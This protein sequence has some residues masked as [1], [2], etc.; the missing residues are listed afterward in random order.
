MKIAIL[1]SALHKYY[2]YYYYLE[3]PKD[4]VVD[5]LLT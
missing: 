3:I 2:Y 5:S 4:V 1:I